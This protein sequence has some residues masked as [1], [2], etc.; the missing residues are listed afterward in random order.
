MQKPVS[1][2]ISCLDLFERDP[3]TKKKNKLHLRKAIIILLLKNSPNISTIGFFLV[4]NDFPLRKDVFTEFNL[5]WL[6][7]PGEGIFFFKNQQSIV[8][9][10][11]SS[12]FK[13]F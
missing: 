2:A 12:P 13:G 1:S 7:G 11:L 6:S 5:N 3:W 10:L 8:P 9:D 4:K